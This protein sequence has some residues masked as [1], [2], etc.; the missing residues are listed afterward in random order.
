MIQA[1]TVNG[2]YVKPNIK[3]ERNTIIL[4][5]IP[6]DTAP[7]AVKAIFDGVEG[8]TVAS[9]RADVGDT[10]FVTMG[11][12]DEAYTTLQRV[13]SLKFQDKP[14]KARLKSENILR[15]FYPAVQAATDRKSFVELALSG[16]GGLMMRLWV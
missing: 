13:G 14:I 1:V 5:E 7:D 9:V 4:R 16:E 2:D 6:S 12:E 10:W 11:S 8:A 3:A 15:S